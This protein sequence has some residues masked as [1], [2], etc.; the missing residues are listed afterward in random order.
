MYSLVWQKFKK[1]VILST[2]M[3]VNVM[4]IYLWE[5]EKLWFS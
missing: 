5:R 2:A 3:D 1:Q 4:V